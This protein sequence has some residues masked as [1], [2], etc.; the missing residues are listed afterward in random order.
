MAVTADVFK[1]L[2]LSATDANSIAGGVNISN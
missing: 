2:N 1:V